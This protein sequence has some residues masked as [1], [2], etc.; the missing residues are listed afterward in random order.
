MLPHLSHVNSLHSHSSFLSQPSPDATGLASYLVKLIA[1]ST[2]V[3]IVIA[4]A[5]PRSQRPPGRLPPQSTA[6]AKPRAQHQS[7]PCHNPPALYKWE[8][9]P[10]G[11][12]R[13][14]RSNPPTPPRLPPRPQLPRE[15][16][17]PAGVPA[18]VEI[19][20]ST[21]H[22]P[23]THRLVPKTHQRPKPVRTIVMPHHPRN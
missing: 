19:L 12:L 21:P 13:R 9:T 23:A 17:H 15:H 8:I 10:P 16:Q 18:I 6:P 22:R 11:P 4:E 5:L 7:R 2:D 20:F 1:T 14:T 3:N